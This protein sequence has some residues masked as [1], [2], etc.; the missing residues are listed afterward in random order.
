MEKGNELE[1]FIGWIGGRFS[2]SIQK[3]HRFQISDNHILNLFG[4]L[5]NAIH[6]H[7]MFC[8]ISKYGYP[9]VLHGEYEIKYRYS[10]YAA[11]A[12][13]PDLFLL[14]KE[15]KISYAHLREYVTYTR[16]PSGLTFKKIFEGINRI[17]E[18]ICALK[19]IDFA[20]CSNEELIAEY[21]HI[22]LCDIQAYKSGKVT[23]KAETQEN[24]LAAMHKIG[25]LYQSMVWK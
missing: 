4:N 14:A 12:L 13:M 20:L 5:Q 7:M 16:K 9:E 6:D 24:L 25:E 19:K 1:V 10:I 3:F 8:R 22:P 23:P 17:G 11:L 15:T 21:S 2:A 18:K